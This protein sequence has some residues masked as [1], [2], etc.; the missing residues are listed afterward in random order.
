MFYTSN[1]DTRI[2]KLYYLWDKSFRVIF[3]GLAN[4]YKIF[5]AGK[6]KGHDFLPKKFL[7][8]EK[9]VNFYLSGKLKN[10][11][12][13]VSLKGFTVF[14]KKVLKTL[15]ETKYGQKVSYMQL[16]DMS[17]FPGTYRAV[18]TCMA[19]NPTMIIIPCHRVIKSDGS[20]GNFSSGI[21]LKKMLLKLEGNG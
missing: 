5:L 6:G 16:A 11:S 12:I 20:M 14:Q 2:G 13:G 7:K 19:H 15:K 18:G 21:N 10:F 4:N 1:F 3:L 17:G 9:E 8:L